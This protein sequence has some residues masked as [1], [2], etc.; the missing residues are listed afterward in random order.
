MARKMTPTTSAS[1]NLDNNVA[2][3]QQWWM[4]G[5]PSTF[6]SPQFSSG[7]MIS[8]QNVPCF[9]APNVAPMTFACSAIFTE[10]P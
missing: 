5:T 2:I 7:R 10:L 6:R 1:T 4:S 8:L 3:A 9:L